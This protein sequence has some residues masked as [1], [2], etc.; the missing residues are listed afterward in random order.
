MQ[1]RGERFFLGGLL[2]PQ[3]VGA[4]DLGAVLQVLTAVPETTE[5]Q[6]SLTA[7]VSGLTVG[8][9]DLL[10]FRDGTVALLQLCFDAI[11][12]NRMFAIVEACTLVGKS[13]SATIWAKTNKY[14]TLEL[15][16]LE[17]CLVWRALEA[18]S[19]SECHIEVLGYGY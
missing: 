19:A 11:P 2:N 18:G 8:K 5:V 6:A 3:A 14:Q 4:E 9:N 1:G 10:K 13:D 12:T 17:T 16:H 15:I 7:K